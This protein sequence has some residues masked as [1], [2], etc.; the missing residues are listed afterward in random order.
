MNSPSEVDSHNWV[1][2]NLVDKQSTRSRVT[3][4]LVISSWIN[5]PPGVGSHYW[6]GDIL[7]DEQA[8]KRSID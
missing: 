1:G 6:V 8:T 3:I 4:G 7:V 2:D 5:S